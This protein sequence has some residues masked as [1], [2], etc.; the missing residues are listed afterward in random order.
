LKVLQNSMKN[1]GPLL[2]VASDT[3]LPISR[4]AWQLAQVSLVKNEF[5]EIDLS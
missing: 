4:A 2:G 5:V 1:A 3:N